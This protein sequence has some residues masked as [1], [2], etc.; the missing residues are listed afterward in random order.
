MTDLEIDLAKENLRDVA[1]TQRAALG[2]AARAAHAKTAAQFFAD[3]IAIPADV[4]VAAYWP[5]RDEI[6]SKPVLIYLMDIL[7]QIV[8]LPVVVGDEQPLVFRQWESDAPLFEAGF[9]ALAPGETSPVVVPD[10]II[11]PLL[12]FDKHGTR[13]GYG[14]G[15]YDRTIAQMA[16]KPITV[17]YAFSAQELDEIPRGAYD[18]PLDY[19]VTENG[20]RRFVS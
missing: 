7:R 5:I 3:E 9:G 1:R 20:V 4:A 17:G 14:R 13:L 8:A 15:Y 10:L 16:K 6:D 11:I 19:L 12:A 2:S 18:Q